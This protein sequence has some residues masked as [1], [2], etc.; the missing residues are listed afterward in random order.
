MDNP[1]LRL[2]EV[3]KRYGE[4]KVVDLLSLDVSEGEVLALL[5]A[6]GS[7]K[8][9]TLRLIAGLE[10]PDAGE[11][12]IDGRPV[13]TKGRNLVQPSARRIGYVF[14]DLA[15]WPHL[16]VAGNLDFV[17]QSSKVPKRERLARLDETLRLVHIEPYAERYPAHLSGGEQQR[18]ALARALVAKPRL[19]LLDE[20]MSSL[21]SHLKAELRAELLD[22]Q[23]SLRITTIYITH[24]HTEA[25]AL[26]D[27]IA[28]MHAGHIE[29]VDTAAV[30]QAQPATETVARF[31]SADAG[32]L[33]EKLDSE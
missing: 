14:Q 21:D 25:Q 28:V 3:T 32:C 12:W 7:G 13:A 30:L 22:L 18:V 6:S 27:R 5:G 10:T 24:D 29:Q 15:L 20:P 17:L 11:V 9:T 4:R 33:P 8:T 23:R 19:L 16:T 26:A 1:F 2:T 31:M